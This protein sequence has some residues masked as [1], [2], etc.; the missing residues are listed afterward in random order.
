[1]FEPLKDSLMSIRGPV[2]GRIAVDRTFPG[3]LRQAGR[4]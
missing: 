2:P 4:P 1:M 3:A